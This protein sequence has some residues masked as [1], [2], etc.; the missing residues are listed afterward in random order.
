MEIS[1]AALYANHHNWKDIHD[2]VTGIP[3]DNKK[4]KDVNEGWETCGIQMSYALNLSSSG[5][6]PKTYGIGISQKKRN[7]IPAVKNLVDF[8]DQN[9]GK[10]ENYKSTRIAM[11]SQIIDRRGIIAFGHRHIDLWD[12]TNI[13][14]PAWYI[15]S[16]LW[17]SESCL[18]RG[19][20]FW[21]I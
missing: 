15:L 2:Y 12:R 11:I 3:K 21:E 5:I 18:K 10:S 4:T 16:A 1:W 19:I 13:H 7:Y 14:R 20:F 6:P 9:Y 8:L 17:E